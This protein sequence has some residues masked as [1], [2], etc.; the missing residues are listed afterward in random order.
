MLTPLQ[1]FLTFLISIVVEALPFVVLGIIISVAVQV[2]LPEGWLLRRLPKRRW[3]RQ[4]TISLLGVFAPVCECGNVPLARGLLVQG[5]S[6]SESLVFLLAAPVLNP[7]TIIT[8]QQAFANDPVVLAGRMAGG[9]VIANVVGWVFMRR[10]RD[11]LLQPDFIKTCQISRHIHE[12]RWARSLELFR[13]EAS[14]ILPALLFGAAAAALV[15]VA[16]P[17]E[18]LL[19]LG[20][21]P[22]WS[23]AAM[24]VLA[25]VISICSNVDA[26]FALAF[27]D[28]FTAGSLVSFLTFGPMI[29]IKLLSLMRTTY[30]PKVLMQVSLLVLLMSAAIGLG[31]SY[32]L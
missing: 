23:I 3:V 25:F 27:R 26:F 18:I 9:F 20:S 32:V 17:R 15:Q 10:R 5:L 29:D 7:V 2:W 31:V 11:E 19:T 24:L 22:A 14:H 12:R 28:T 4:V 8:T 16:V 6:A 1:D 30:Q 13:H 21:N